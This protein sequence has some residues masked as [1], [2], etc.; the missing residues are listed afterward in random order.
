MSFTKVNY[1]NNE[2]IISAE[3]LNDIQDAILNGY[4]PAGSIEAADFAPNAIV[5]AVYPIGSIYM[6]VNNISPAMQ[7]GGTWES[8]NDV[9]LMCGGSTYGYGAFGGSKTH[10]HTTGNCTL[11]TS[12]MP[13]HR[14]YPGNYDTAGSDTSYNRHFT[15]HLHLSSDSTARRTVG[16][17]G[18]HYAITASTS[19]D[20]TGVATTT[21]TGGGQ[22]HN[23]GNTGSSSN[24]PPYLTVYTWK[25]IA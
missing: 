22:A 23:H 25:R 10:T 3:N 2:T 21:Y 15:T 18:D 17:G 1:I 4:Q 7:F 16:S 19:G 24:L 8:I 14:H 5:E 13:S 20:I 11:T 12:Q 6:S 9:F